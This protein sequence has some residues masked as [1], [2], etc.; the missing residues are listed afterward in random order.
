MQGIQQMFRQHNVVDKQS[1]IDSWHSA[2]NNSSCSSY[3]NGR[4]VSVESVNEMKPWNQGLC[5]LHCFR[6][7]QKY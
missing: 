6:I 7:T 2:S 4:E 1:S 5:R 3:T